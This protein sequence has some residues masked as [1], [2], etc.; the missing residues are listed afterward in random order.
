MNVTFTRP[1]KITTANG[2]QVTI[3]V[4]AQA[5]AK[6]VGWTPVAEGAMYQLSGEFGV[7]FLPGFEPTVRVDR[8]HR[9]TAHAE[10]L[11]RFCRNCH[12][13]GQVTHWRNGR[14]MDLLPEPRPCTACEG[15]GHAK[16]YPANT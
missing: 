14:S 16:T 3:P 11:H 6:F 4:G 13:T 2:R 8:L 1:L 9:A 15:T 10:D 12:F 7:R 5:E